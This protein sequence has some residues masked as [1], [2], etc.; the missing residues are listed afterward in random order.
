MRLDD[1]ELPAASHLTGP[2]AIDALRVPVEAA[3][4]VI[5]SCRVRQVQYRPG[6]DLVVQFS[7]T[8][9]WNGAAPVRETLLAS[10]TINGPLAGTVAVE[11]S[12]SKGPLSVGLWRWPFDPAL[13][14][15]RTAVTSKML[16]SELRD[17]VGTEPMTLEVVAYRP[18]ERVVVKVTT[19][20]HQLFVKVLPL[21]RAEVLGER[22]RQLR[23]AGLPVPSILGLVPESGLLVMDAVA[24]P[25]LKEMIKTDAGGW[26]DA[27]E[28]HRLTAALGDAIMPEAPIVRRRTDDA[29]LHARMLADVFPAREG[30]LGELAEFFAD[31]HTAHPTSVIHGDLHESQLV[32][33]QGKITGVLDI[34]DCGLGAPVD[35]AATVIA[36]L[37]YR[38]LTT[39]TVRERLNEYADELRRSWLPTFG[40]SVLD[41]ATAAT[42][43]GLATGPYRVQQADWQAT[44]GAVLDT[45][46]TLLDNAGHER[47][48]SMPS[49]R[50]HLA[51]PRCHR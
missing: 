1:H 17:L 7:A 42:L 47:T 29:A 35:D 18:T 28:Y 10:T 9:S 20:R 41:H 51:E 14:G 27:T 12:T 50:A 22:H 16:A 34:D 6:S 21:G 13:P 33:D 37:R 44:S 39:P 40:P 3:G 8:V 43:V 30:Q 26:P 38:A 49:S 32:I 2:G 23:A 45:C 15:L 48:L 46:A 25:T 36:F 4:G 19:S 24:G 31:D 11:A 5:E